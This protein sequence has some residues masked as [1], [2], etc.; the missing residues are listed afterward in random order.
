VPLK[1]RRPTKKERKAVNYGDPRSS[2]RKARVDFMRTK[3]ISDYPLLIGE[4]IR[5]SELRK[6]RRQRWSAFFKI[7]RPAQKA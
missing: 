4:L 3:T 2:F 6:T 7:N 1:W 5:R